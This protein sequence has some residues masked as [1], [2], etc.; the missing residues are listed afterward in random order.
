MDFCRL[1][2]EAEPASPAE[3]FTR[4]SASISSGRLRFNEAEAEV[5]SSI[6]EVDVVASPPASSSESFVVSSSASAG[7]ESASASV[8]RMGNVVVFVVAG[9]LVAL[10]ARDLCFLSMRSLCFL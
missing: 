10:E 5:S 1:E 2:G 3:P 8:C 9:V 6:G 4:F 7:V